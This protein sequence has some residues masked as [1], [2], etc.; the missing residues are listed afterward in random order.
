VAT[1]GEAE[2]PGKNEAQPANPMEIN[3][4]KKKPG[5]SNLIMSIQILR[6]YRPYISL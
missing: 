2:A 5:R 1:G 6:E 4:S 3:T